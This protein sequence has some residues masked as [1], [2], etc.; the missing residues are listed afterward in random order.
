MQ[1]T[2]TGSEGLKREFRVVV[3]AG[4]MDGKVAARLEE[5][6]G[7]VRING[8]RPGKVPLDHLRRVYGRAVMA[9]TIESTVREANSSIASERGLKLAMD[10]KVTLPSEEDAVKAMVD[11]RADLAFTVEMEVLPTIELADFKGIALEKLVVEVTE[12]EIDEAIDRIARQNR[13]Y[14]DKGEGARA[15]D[16]DRVTISF[17]GTIDG[18]QF[19][20]GKGEDIPVD[21][22]S[23]TFLPG[24]EEQLIGIKAGEARTV[25]AT[26]PANYGKADLAG[27]EASFEVTAKSIESPGEAKGGDELAT[28]LGIESMAKLR[29]AVRDRIAQEHGAA[30]R[31][32]IKRALLDALDAQHRFDLPPTLAE[33]EFQNVWKTVVSDLEAQ[34]R[35]LADE[36][37]D[38]NE[39]KAEYRRIA[40]RRVRL[41]LVLAEIGERNNIK[42]TDEEVSRAVVERARQFPGQE[43]RLWEFYRSNPSALASLR[44]P[45]YEEKVVDFLLE[46]AKVTEKKVTREELYKEDESDTQAA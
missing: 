22:G 25:T 16:G 31:R 37:T 3:P 40:E 18:V 17:V 2:E 34:G 12:A 7:R 8:F 38:E 1:V 14:A 5:L 23:K 10:P 13:P 45:I 4:E 39:A 36:T 21:L 44:A 27:K 11:G 43:Q 29:D 24:F 6:K 26:F 33:E 32:R 15:E 46:L 28:T 20:G 9:E 30:S 19:E 42:V 41:G 35:T